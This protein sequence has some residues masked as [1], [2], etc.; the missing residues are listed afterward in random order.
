MTHQSSND[1]NEKIPRSWVN[2][3][4]CN[5]D[6]SQLVYETVQFA[7]KTLGTLK[8]RLVMCDECDFVY[9]NPRPSR[10]ILATYY[11]SDLNASG[12]IFRQAVDG[13]PTDIIHRAHLDFLDS[14]NITPK[15]LLDV[16]CGRGFFLKRAT[17][18]YPMANM[19]GVEPSEVALANDD[20]EGMLVHHGTLEELAP[21]LGQ[22][23]VICAFSV[24]EHV[25]HPLE[26]LN[27]LKTLLTPDGML[28][29]EVPESCYPA[30]GLVE[31]FNFEHLGHF[32]SSTLRRILNA[33]GLEMTAIAENMRP[34]GRLV[35]SA[36]G[37]GTA[38]QQSLP[39]VNADFEKQRFL[40]AV[41]EYKIE[42]KSLAE[43]FRSRLLQN[44]SQWSKDQARVGVYGAG[45]HTEYLLGVLE[46]L[47]SVIFCLLDSDPRKQGQSFYQWPVYGPDDI[48]EL[49]LDA[50]LISSQRFE[51]EIYEAL[52]FHRQSGLTVIRC[53]GD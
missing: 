8:T 48:E 47:A 36:V 13:G 24:L 53:Y 51:D 19:V 43:A 37:Q 18:H 12:Q 52:N 11:E 7:G 15:K 6:K 28:F 29:L 2:C 45:I 38:R 49:S 20:Q 42:M 27:L 32:T 26:F 10:E 31:F 23:D 30:A 35:V 22:F 1:G 40:K 4:L 41:A 3:P 14:Q 17:T 33:A 21:Q 44:V 16:G 9:N 46:E 50:I 5:S 25:G 34:G 39:K